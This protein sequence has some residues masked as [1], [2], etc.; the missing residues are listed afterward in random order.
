[1]KPSGQLGS[2]KALLLDTKTDIKTQ[3]FAKKQPN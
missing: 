1:M 3:Y 2:L